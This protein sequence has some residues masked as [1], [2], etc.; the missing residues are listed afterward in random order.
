M[1]LVTFS[2]VT[3]I[4]NGN[5]TYQVNVTVNESRPVSRCDILPDGPINCYQTTEV[6]QTTKLIN[7]STR[8]SK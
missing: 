2:V 3:I 5:N 7:V 4:P 8:K 1:I 6:Y